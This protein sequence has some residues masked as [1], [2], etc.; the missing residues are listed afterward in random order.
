MRLNDL[1]LLLDVRRLPP[2]DISA[3]WAQHSGE[4]EMK[5]RL[6]VP[7][8]GLTLALAASISIAAQVPAGSARPLAH[9]GTSKAPQPSKAPE[10][11]GGAKSEM[12]AHQKD[13]KRGKQTCISRAFRE[14]AEDALDALERL[15]TVGDSSASIYEPAGL[16][17]L[18]QI[19]KAERAATNQAEDVA[20]EALRSYLATIAFCRRMAEIKGRFS[21][22]MDPGDPSKVAAYRAIRDQRQCPAKLLLLLDAKRRP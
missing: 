16:E 15:T 19:Q 7:L 20:I 9:Q 12:A 17:A 4:K 5:D 2:F 13:L 11:A 21:D 14:S 1:L 6:A 18:K 10:K 22:W 8:V 3:L